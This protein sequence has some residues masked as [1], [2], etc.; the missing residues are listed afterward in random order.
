[1]NTYPHI[2]HGRDVDNDC[3]SNEHNTCCLHRYN[4]NP[5]TIFFSY[6]SEI[7]EERLNNSFV[8]SVKAVFRL[9]PKGGN[10]AAL[11]RKEFRYNIDYAVKLANDNGGLTI[12]EIEKLFSDEKEMQQV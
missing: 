2:E 11:R 1:M 9:Y 12:L 10:P 6:F 7:G 8:Q 3:L 4:T 5:L